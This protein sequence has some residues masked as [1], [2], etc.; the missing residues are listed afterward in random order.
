LSF[1]QQNAVLIAA[2]SVGL[3]L[4]SCDQPRRTPQTKQEA[5][6]DLRITLGGFREGHPDEGKLEGVCTPDV[7]RT[8]MDCDVYNDLEGWTVSEVTLVVT[9]S[10]YKDDDKRYYAQ[11]VSIEPLTP[12]RVSIRLGIQLPEDTRLKFRGGRLGPPES[13]WGWQIVEAKGHRIP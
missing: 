1:A 11:R 4:F 10:A 3:S 2:A 9:W 8:I 7:T 12:Q 13:H 5:D 6:S